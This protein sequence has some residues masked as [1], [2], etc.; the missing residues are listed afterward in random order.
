M[1]IFGF[2]L[3]E[4]FNIPVMLRPTTRV[5]HARADVNAGA[6]LEAAGQRKFVKNPARRV[7]LPVH[8]RPLHNELVA[9][10]A[11]I[12]EELK[13]A[14]WNRLDLRGSAGIIA[15]GIAGLYAEEAIRDLDLDVSLLRIGTYPVPSGMIEEMLLHVSRVLVVEELEPVVEEKVERIARKVNPGVEILGKGEYIPRAGELDFL[16]VRNAL[17]RMAGL[18]EKPAR[19]VAAEGIAAP[20]AAGALSRLQPPLHLLCHEEGLR[21]ERRLS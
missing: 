15:S 2:E 20:Q 10:Q 8:V 6:A 19:R 3:S 21:Q 12:E 5:S 14:P 11:A 1:V 7:A 18:H 4:K 9:K 13:N 16:A 17:A